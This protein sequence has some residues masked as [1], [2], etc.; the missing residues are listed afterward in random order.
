MS[1]TDGDLALSYLNSLIS[2]H[3]EEIE[4][5]L[6]AK[7][8]PITALNRARARIRELLDLK[9]AYLA[10]DPS[11]ISDIMRLKEESEMFAF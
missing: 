8:K 10:N 4:L 9:N 5:L 3:S 6:L 7:P 1:S 2:R 11:R